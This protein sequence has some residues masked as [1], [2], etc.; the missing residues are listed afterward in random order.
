MS[1][2][3]LYQ[4]FSKTLSIQVGFFSGKHRFCTVSRQNVIGSK[5]ADFIQLWKKFYKQDAYEAG[6]LKPSE[7]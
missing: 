3:I 6:L 5:F 7:E 2:A 4:D 1:N